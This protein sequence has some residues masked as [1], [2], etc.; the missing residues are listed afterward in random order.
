MK[1]KISEWNLSLEELQ[2]IILNTLENIINHDVNALTQDESDP[3]ST[4]DTDSKMD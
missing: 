4:Y 2:Q 3:D 1:K